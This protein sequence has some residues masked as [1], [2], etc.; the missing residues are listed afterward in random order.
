M[1]HTNDVGSPTSQ[2][3]DLVG[4]IGLGNMGAPMATRLLEWPGGLIVCDVRDDAVAN[5]EVLDV[6]PHLHD[7][8]NRFVAGYELHTNHVP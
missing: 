3:A 5:L 4:Y 8:P 1:P 7:R 2:G 6:P